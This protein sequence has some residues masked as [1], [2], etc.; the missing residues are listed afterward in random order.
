[1]FWLVW[2]CLVNNR[3][4]VQLQH[5][6]TDKNKAVQQPWLD[7]LVFMSYNSHG[8]VHTFAALLQHS[9]LVLIS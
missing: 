3:S 7:L 1:M 9:V 6:T 2:I 8:L 5:S 4:M